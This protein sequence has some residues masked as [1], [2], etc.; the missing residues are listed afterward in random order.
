MSLSIV[1]VVSNSDS[2]SAVSSDALQADTD[3]LADF[4]SVRRRLFGIAY[5]MLGGVADAE[6]V[7]QDVWVRW[8][9]ADRARVRDRT[10]FLVTIT[11]RVALTAVTSARV[12]RE[13]SVGDWPHERE[14]ESVDPSAEAERADAVAGAVQLL[15]ER[16]T[17]L[18]RAA[19]VLR[20]AF[21]H[22]F[23]EIADALGTSEANARQ[24]AHRARKHLGG[25]RCGPVGPQERDELLGAFLDAS[26]EGEMA[27]L[28]DLL[29]ASPAS[30]AA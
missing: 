2:S 28:V 25:H 12:R 11:T 18:E 21:D 3:A 22:P 19:Y 24:L 7:V 17:P 20:E 10:A 6:D 30:A 4:E 26:R 15:I 27:R 14:S 5:R 29:T 1:G 13:V 23:C 8:Q 16:L 9:S